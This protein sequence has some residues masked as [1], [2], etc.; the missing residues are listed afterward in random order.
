MSRAKQQEV[1]QN[2]FDL[3]SEIVTF[4][5]C[6]KMESTHEH[7]VCAFT[8]KKLFNLAPKF[9]LPLNNPLIIYK[10]MFEVEIISEKQDKYLVLHNKNIV[11]DHNS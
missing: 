1:E 7:K 8:T 10:R 2:K 5:A 3:V 4:L 6:L 11:S 9:P